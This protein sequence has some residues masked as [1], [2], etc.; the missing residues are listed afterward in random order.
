MRKPRSFQCNRVSIF[1]CDFFVNPFKPQFFSL[2]FHWHRTF[3]TKATNRINVKLR[4]LLHL[5]LFAGLLFLLCTHAVQGQTYTVT[6]IAGSD[7]V[8]YQ[9]GVGTAAR[10][11][12]PSGLVFDAQDNVIVADF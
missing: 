8:G 11:Y 6:T 2:P 7:T 10:F 12:G 9:D 1:N 5:G 4:F 3:N